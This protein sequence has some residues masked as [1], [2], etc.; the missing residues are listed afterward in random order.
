MTTP[1]PAGRRRQARLMRLVN[2]PM[3]ALLRLPLATPLGDRLMLVT[4]TGRRTGRRY[5]QPLSYVRDGDTLLT[6]G[7]GRWTLNLRPDQPN[8]IRLRGRDFHAYP[9]AVVDLDAVDELLQL[10]ADANPSSQ[11]F[12]RILRQPDGHHDAQALRA[13]IDNGFCIIRWRPT[14]DVN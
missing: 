14:T 10:I 5:R 11:R 13:A 9:D 4:I 3:R 2:V 12:V 7:G 6:P 1:T 8:S